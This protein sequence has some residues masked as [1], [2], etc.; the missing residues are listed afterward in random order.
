MILIQNNINISSKI[1][2]K[3]KVTYKYLFVHFWMFQELLNR[4][5]EVEPDHAQKKIIIKQ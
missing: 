1:K 4:T 3:I 5:T 2:N